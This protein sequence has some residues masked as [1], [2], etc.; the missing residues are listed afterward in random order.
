MLGIEGFDKLVV[1]YHNSE[2]TE[3]KEENR[4]K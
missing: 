2:R 3:R 4:G 1:M